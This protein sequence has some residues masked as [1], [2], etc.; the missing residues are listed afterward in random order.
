MSEQ[1]LKEILGELKALNQRAGNM[2]QRIGNVEQRIGGL[3]Q[4]QQELVKRVGGLEQGQQELAKRVGGLEQ[5]QQELAG[6]MERMET[7]I[8]NE[9]IDKIRA[10]FD[11]RAVHMD[12]FVSIRNSLAKIEDRVE[13]IARRQIE[14]SVK[15]EEHDREIRLLR[16]EI[17]GQ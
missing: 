7:R 16:L 12:Y 17:S 6:R 4:G 5:G 8:E 10:L 2:E 1:L 9:I 15:L 14:T 13:Y 11:A 3:E